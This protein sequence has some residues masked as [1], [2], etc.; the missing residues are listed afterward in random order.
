MLSGFGPEQELKRHDIN[1]I[2]SIPG[3]GQNLQD[4][5]FV[6]TMYHLKEEHYDKVVTKNSFPKN[7]KSPG[8][9]SICS[10]L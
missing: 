3:I 8:M 1:V 2:E 4:H 6:M 7:T 10:M 9:F 5:I